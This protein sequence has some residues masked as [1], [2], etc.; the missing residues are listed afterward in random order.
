I[1][2]TDGE[3]GNADQQPLHLNERQLEV[4]RVLRSKAKPNYPFHDWYIGALSAV[5][6]ADA[7]NPDRLAQAANSL[8]EVLEKIPRALETQVS[9][10]DRNILEQRRKS[11]ADA[12][13]RAKSDYPNGWIG[14]ISAKLRGALGQVEQ[15]IDLRG[16]PTR[17]QRTFA[18]LAKL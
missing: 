8:R 11:M 17:A 18:G 16:S 12:I 6:L 2:T 14:E 7:R 10:P 3:S 1:V 5:A 13:V 9:G 4:W 15:Y